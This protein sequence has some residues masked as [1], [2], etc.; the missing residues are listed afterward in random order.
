MEISGG[1]MAHVARRLFHVL[2]LIAVPYIYYHWFVDAFADQL[3]PVYVVLVLCF[4][5][6]VFEIFRIRFGWLFFGQRSYEAKRFSA[7]AW[8]VIGLTVLLIASPSAQVTMPIAM[9][10]ALA[11]P[12]AGELRAWQ[13]NNKMVFLLPKELST[14]LKIRTMNGLDPILK[15]IKIKTYEKY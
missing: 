1:L 4:L 8:T 9:S 7:F 11:D 13:V 12:L 10:C 6:L 15:L 3:V 14:G 2:S 5:V